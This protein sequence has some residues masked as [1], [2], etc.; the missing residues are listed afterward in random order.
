M[1]TDYI[2]GQD[3]MAWITQ[4]EIADRTEEHLGMTDKGIILYRRM[5]M[6]QMKKLENGEDPK[7]VFRDPAKNAKIELPQEAEIFQEGTMLFKVAKEWNTKYAPNIE[8]ILDILSRRKGQ[9]AK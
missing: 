8:E 5:L 2:D 1:V 3:A 4:G 6:E 9:E 7:N